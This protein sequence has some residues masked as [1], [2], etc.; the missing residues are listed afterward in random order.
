MIWVF[1][2]LYWG[3]WAGLVGR[4]ERAQGRFFLAHPGGV[5]VVGG[6]TALARLRALA[7]T[8]AGV[9]LPAALPGYGGTASGPP[10]PSPW[11]KG[12]PSGPPLPPPR[13]GSRSRR[14]CPAMAERRRRASS[15]R[16]PSVPRNTSN[17]MCAPCAQSSQWESHR[18][19]ST[20]FCL[21]R[22]L[23]TL[24]GYAQPPSASLA[25]SSSH[26]WWSSGRIWWNMG[27]AKD[28]WAAW[29]PPM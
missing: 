29:T 16:C 12:P 14:R 26:R 9:S 10:L 24:T 4:R 19:M 6:A 8:A 15:E 27:P 13:L 22:V 28:L 17:G 7:A 3:F 21:E 5:R 1:L 25:S 18:L 2:F 23:K 11:T 20:N